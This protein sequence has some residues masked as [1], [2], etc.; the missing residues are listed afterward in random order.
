M[1]GTTS[2]S[3]CISPSSPRSSLAFIINFSHGSSNSV[4]VKGIDVLTR[5]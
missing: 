5:R 4:S 1:E 2:G 3:A